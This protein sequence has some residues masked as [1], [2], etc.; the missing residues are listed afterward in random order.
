MNIQIT[1]H[2]EQTRSG[3]DRKRMR[4][5][6]KKGEKGDEKVITE[7]LQLNESGGKIRLLLT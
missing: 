3:K 1:G 7:T 4:K 6:R 5:G 2:S